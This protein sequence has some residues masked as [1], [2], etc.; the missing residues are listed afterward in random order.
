VILLR[1]FGIFGALT[2]YFLLLAEKPKVRKQKSKK[3]SKKRFFLECFF[4]H[5]FFPIPYVFC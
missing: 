3:S 4:P 1:G 5:N 2:F